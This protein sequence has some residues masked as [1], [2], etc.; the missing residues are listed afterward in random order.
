M[1]DVHT[2]DVRSKNMRAIRSANT[3]PELVLRKALHA[4]GFRYR[5][6]KKDFPC[7][8]DILLTKYQTAIFVHGCFWHGHSCKYFRL[9][10]SR[11]E[12][13]SNKINQNKARD[14]NATNKL[15][16]YGWNVVVVW[17]CAL[18]PSNIGM[19][20]VVRQVSDFLLKERDSPDLLEIPA[21]AL[22]DSQL[23]S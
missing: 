7:K 22:S 23:S 11:P 15:N 1:V 17:E 13:W 12:F 10:Q 2:P 6:T 4:A 18:R 8:P 16:Q 20:E 3:K 9:P 21:S 5:L 19:A 14:L